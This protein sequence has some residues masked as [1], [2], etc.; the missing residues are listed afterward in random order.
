[1]SSGNVDSSLAIA[2]LL[3]HHRELK[4]R[5]GL[6]QSR[7]MDFFR[8]KRFIKALKSPEYAKKAANQPDLYPPVMGAGDEDGKAR[9]MFVSLIKAQLIVPCVKLHS[10]ECK[11]HGIKPSK[12]HPSLILSNKAELLADEYYVWTYNP[13][14]FMDY[15]IV[16]GVISAILALVCY[17]LWPPFMRRGSYYVSLGALAFLGL[18]FVMAIIRLIV[19]VISLA[20]V[21]SE[22]GFWLFP[23]LFEDCGVLESFKPL[24]GYGD[25]ECYSYLKKLKRNRRKQAK[26]A[27]K[28]DGTSDK[29]K[30]QDNVEDTL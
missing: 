5:K 30:T 26:K 24:Y 10:E 29:S 3:R 20:F 27:A 21:R 1:M 19:Y 12:E 16:T 23:N 28:L 13:K 25:N 18:F 15:L 7:Q 2:K 9:E 8:Y 14:T 17:P 6:F 4:Q 11:E 22:G